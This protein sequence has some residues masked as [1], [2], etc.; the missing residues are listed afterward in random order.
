MRIYDPRNIQ[1]LP[2]LRTLRASRPGDS[3]NRQDSSR[4]QR[5][6]EEPAYRRQA[7]HHNGQGSEDEDQAAGVAADVH[8][9]DIDAGGPIW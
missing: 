4:C 2:A 5:G 6:D 3:G 8:R 9:R 7:Q 1:R